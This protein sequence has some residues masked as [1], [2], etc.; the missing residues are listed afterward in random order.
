MNLNG[1]KWNGD[2][3]LMRC[4]KPIDEIVSIIRHKGIEI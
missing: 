3:M 2:E 1:K 4:M